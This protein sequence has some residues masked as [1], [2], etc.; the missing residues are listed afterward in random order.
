MGI[1]RAEVGCP[2]Y[3][4]DDGEKRI[5]CEGLTDPSTLSQRFGRKRYL[6]NYMEQYCFRRCTDCELFR[7]LLRVK[8]AD[9]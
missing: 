9:E 8:Y 7:L 6:K 2:F 4:Y 1:E 5:V 3:R